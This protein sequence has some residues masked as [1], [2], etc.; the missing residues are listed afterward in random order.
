MQRTETTTRTL[1]YSAIDSEI[2][3]DD[4]RLGEVI[5]WADANPVVWKIVQSTRSKVFGKSAYPNGSD[6]LG[7]AAYFK[8]QLEP[9]FDPPAFQTPAT[10]WMWRARFT[11]EHYEDKNFRSGFFQQWDGTYDRGCAYLDYTPDT[12]DEVVQAFADWCGGK[13]GI[14]GY[15][16]KEI[17][18]DGKTVA[19]QVG[20]RLLPENTMRKVLLPVNR[21][22][23]VKSYGP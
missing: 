19:K 23:K 4:P 18:L 21:K 2:V 8:A 20:E 5:D 14:F 12:L 13:K 1:Y 9:H 7:R 6:T 3:T 17:R 16:T 11:L 22:S 10:F 15:E